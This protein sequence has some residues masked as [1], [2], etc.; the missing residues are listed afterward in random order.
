[1]TQML[2]AA[3]VQNIIGPSRIIG[4]AKE[5][6]TDNTF[7]IR[8]EA[9][10]LNLDFMSYSMYS[11]A[12]EDP[13]A[14]L[15]PTVFSRLSSKTFSTFFQHFANSNL[16][17]TTGSWVYQ[18][19]NASLPPDL[20]PAVT[21]ARLL[22][23]APLTDYQDEIHPI[24]HTNRTV[25][26]RVSK[27]VEMLQMNAVAVWLSVSILAWLITATVIVTVFHRQYLRRL[28]RNVE[29]LGDMLVLTAGSENLVQLIREM[30][31]G[32][33]TES[34]KSHLC[35]RLG[36]FQDGDGKARWGVEVSEGYKGQ[37]PV[38]WLDHDGEERNRGEHAG[39]T[40]SV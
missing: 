16:F 8:D 23:D 7:N 1:M 22:G 34:E 33:L 20:T 36:W 21:D 9:H 37:P 39:D 17:M 31:A 18:P 35:T 2:T 13:A 11:L 10:G 29:C 25:V 24:S 28:I 15:D 3:N 19:I 27:R 30:Q 6:R 32:N 38:Q 5:D 26:V 12:G 4:W 14:L 40:G